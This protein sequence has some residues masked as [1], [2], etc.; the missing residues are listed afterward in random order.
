MLTG[1]ADFRRRIA[2]AVA[3][4]KGQ[5]E[6]VKFLLQN[7]A[8]MDVSESGCNPLIGTIPGRHFQVARILVEAGIDTKVKYGDKDAQEVARVNGA[9]E[10]YELLSDKPLPVLKKIKPVNLIEE[11]QEASW[12]SMEA[13]NVWKTPS[14]AMAFCLTEEDGFIWLSTSDESEFENRK[15]LVLSDSKT[16]ELLKEI[17]VDVDQHILGS[18]RWNP[19]EWQR[20]E[21]KTFEPWPGLCAE[22]SNQSLGDA[23]ASLVIALR[24]LR[25][26]D[27]FSSLPQ[28][29][30]I[31]LF[32]S[33]PDSLETTWIERESA[34]LL[35][36]PTV[37]E[38]FLRD[39]ISYIEGP[40]DSPTPK[41]FLAA[42]SKS[43]LF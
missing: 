23:V 18:A 10:I 35:N 31:T 24:K 4:G 36:S 40:E 42:I 12:V 39:A 7:G 32:V 3:A 17:Q 14:Y 25:D 5:N 38:S 28:H 34:K 33:C 29:E 1:K 16:L 41:E 2:Y 6:V 19:F 37:Y 9:T 43:N 15:Q 21:M 30:S 8:E 11:L 26:S 13:M 27:R 22:E 20:Q